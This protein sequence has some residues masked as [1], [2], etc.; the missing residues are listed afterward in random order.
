MGSLA[1]RDMAIVLQVAPFLAVGAV[2]ALAIPRLLD[3]LAMGDDVARALGQNLGV[4][5]ALAGLAAVILAGASTAAAGPI[6]FV[7]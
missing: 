2:L 6:G 3:G 4:S 5:R 7:G 1:G